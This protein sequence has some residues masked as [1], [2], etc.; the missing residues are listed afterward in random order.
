VFHAPSFAIFAD[1]LVGWVCAPGRRT[2]TAMISAT[3]AVGAR[4][5]D[6][7]HR[8]VRDGARAMSG[9]WRAGQPRGGPLRPHC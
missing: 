4:A 7:Y 1:L 2:I 9:L 6:A 5:Y 8:F 3:D